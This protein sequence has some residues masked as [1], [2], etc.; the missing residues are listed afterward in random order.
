M[1]F[2]KKE[3]GSVISFFRPL[4]GLEDITEKEYR[5][6]MDNVIDSLESSQTPP[7]AEERIEALE[8]AMLELIGVTTND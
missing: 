6:A 7:T 3:N 1:Y 2:Y 8:S 4:D 5:L